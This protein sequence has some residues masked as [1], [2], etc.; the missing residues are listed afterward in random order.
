MFGLGML[1][2]ERDDFEEAKRCLVRAARMFAVQENKPWHTRALD[3]LGTVQ[4]AAARMT[5]QTEPA[6][7]T[8][9]S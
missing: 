4:L 5:P 9:L 1:H 8:G 3:E 6:R 2:A 7:P